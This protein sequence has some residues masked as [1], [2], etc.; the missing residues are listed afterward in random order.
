MH[1]LKR[2]ARS[3]RSKELE[4]LWRRG[5]GAPCQPYWL[6]PPV[7]A[8][9]AQEAKRLLSGVMNVR[10]TRIARRGILTAMRA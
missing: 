1:L 7:L 6:P 2:P 4:V 10:P 5:S 3:E 8:H 9:S